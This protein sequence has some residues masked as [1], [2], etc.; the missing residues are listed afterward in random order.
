MKQSRLILIFSFLSV[1][2]YGQ[3]D[4]V[5]MMFYNLL[6]FPGSKPE[7]INSLKEV[8][9]N[10]QPDIFMVCE[11]E[12]STASVSILTQALNTDGINRFQKTVFW[13]NGNFNNMLYYDYN[14]FKIIKQD[15]IDSWPRFATAYKLMHKEAYSNNDSIVFTVIVV[16][17][18]AGNEASNATARA[19]TAK[20]IKYYI[21]HKTDRKNIFV[22]GDFN[23]Y[24][25]TEEAFTYLTKGGD[26]ELEDPVNEIGEWNN[27]EYYSPLHTQSTRTTSFGGG[28]TGGLDDRF[29]WILISSDVRNAENGLTYIP[30]SYEAFGNDGNHFN[31]AINAGKNNS[32]PN[33]VIEALHEMSD[34]LPVIMQIAVNTNR[35]GIA[36]NLRKMPEMKVDRL[37]SRI[38]IVNAE[39]KYLNTKCYDLSGKLLG[40]STTEITSF[41]QLGI[42]MKGVYIVVSDIGN[43][44]IYKKIIL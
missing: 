39:S 41:S 8:I 2:A 34:H 27:K 38:E 18:K 15:T 17:L 31:M 6:Q 3:V 1:F 24:S 26:T 9:N 33:E 19:K 11:L 30:K 37:N 5:N 14:K 23:V 42:N 43:D 35:T 28:S 25:G 10:A 29:D 7:R 21:D 44:R 20:R 16:H 4:T 12:T 22:A 36:K 40:E 32:K 13:Y